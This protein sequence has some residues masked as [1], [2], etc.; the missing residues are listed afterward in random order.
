MAPEPGALKAAAAAAAE[1]APPAAELAAPAAP[2]ATARLSVPSVP[3]TCS[4]SAGAAR[5]AASKPLMA[6]HTSAADTSVSRSAA[7][8][9]GDSR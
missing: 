9:D 6:L 3:F 4:R 5:P 1:A 7:K 8:A 2:A